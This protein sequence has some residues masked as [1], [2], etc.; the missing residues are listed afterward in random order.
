VVKLK[1]IS[2]HKKIKNGLFLLDDG[3]EVFEASVFVDVIGLNLVEGDNS[4]ELFA[5]EL[6]KLK[7]EI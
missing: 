4:T 1:N 5:C 3:F 2:T 7:K 6:K